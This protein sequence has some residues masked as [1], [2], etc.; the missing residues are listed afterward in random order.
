MSAPQELNNLIDALRTISNECK[1][2]NGNCFAC[3]LSLDDY[4]CGV[5]GQK[6]CGS[7]DYKVKPQ[8]WDIPAVRLLR[9]PKE[10]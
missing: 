1:S 5:T 9:P 3:P 8:Y 10:N 7:Y 4:K 2:H 6:T